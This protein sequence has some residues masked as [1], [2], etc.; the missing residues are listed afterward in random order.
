MRHMMQ[1]SISDQLQAYLLTIRSP[2]PAVA[3]SLAG[4]ADSILFRYL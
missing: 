2:P 3:A 4:K 1:L